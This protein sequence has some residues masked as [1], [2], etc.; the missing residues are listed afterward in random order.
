MKATRITTVRR[1]IAGISSIFLA[2]IFIGISWFVIH[3]VTNE[4]TQSS[5]IYMEALSL[6]FA[7]EA[8]AILEV[9]LDSA[10]TLAQ[11][12]EA[13]SQSLPND[14][15]KLS[16]QQAQVL[17]Q[18][19]S[20]FLRV[21]FYLN[22]GTQEGVAVT[23]NV[24]NGR[25]TNWVPSN[26]LQAQA[27]DGAIS[28]N[29]EQ[30]SE[31]FY[32]TVGGVE[33][34]LISL[35]GPITE[36]GRVIG[37]VG[38]DITTDHLARQL[39]R[40][41]LFDTGFGR[42]MSALGTVVVHPSASRIN[43]PAP[44]WSDSQA[45]ELLNTLEQGNIFTDLYIS[46]ATGEE[47]FK[48][49]VPIQVGNTP[50]PWYFGTVVLPSEVYAST[51]ILGT[52]LS[53]ILLF[54]FL[55]IVT[56]IM[57]VSGK[58]LRPLKNVQEGLSN[59]AQGE[60]DL[61]RTLQV[62]T[63]DE[64][65][66]LS[67]DFNSFVGNLNHIIRDI[68]IALESLKEAGEGVDT[69]M[70]RT[71]RGHSEIESALDGVKKT[72]GNQDL[73]IQTMSSTVEQISGNIE[74]LNSL[75]QRQAGSL[76]ESSSAI[77]EMVAN[78][79]S[80]TNNLETNRKSFE[81][82]DQVSERGFDQLSSVTS[83]ISSI[84]EQSDGLEEANSIITSIASQTNLLAMNAAIE[85]AHA[86]EA[87]KGFAVVADEIRK[88]AENSAEQSLTI[89]ATLK[90]LQ[91][92]IGSVVK[93]AGDSSH[94]FEEVRS[95]VRQVL[96]LQNEMRTAMKEQQTGSEMVLN[97]IEE[98]HRITQE[99]TLGSKEMSTGSEDILREVHQLVGSSQQMS[100]AL[101]SLDRSAETIST[102]ITEMKENTQK[103]AEGIQKVD[104]Q[105]SRFRI[106]V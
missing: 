49:F 90:A 19:N 82:L 20:D 92:A 103:N 21:W 66:A 72:M 95:S 69:N 38:I 61:T 81:K 87:G 26:S 88:L 85:A 23:K 76:S 63:R 74:S 53:F 24:G 5:I 48:A 35:I 39:S 57:T 34:Y 93:D 50:R 10:R 3:Q 71:V 97:S 68:R 64:L 33:L 46:V 2:L 37:A 16:G 54:G 30:I 59:I 62:T 99:V 83:T 105:T 104:E 7:N 36:N 80:V 31:P 22:G 77:E 106:S 1:K 58:I 29:I 14:A 11:G 12:Y 96:A 86:G 40:V 27:L 55:L 101:G 89:G 45:S 94:S 9:P 56:A 78:I 4:K 15:L 67:Q 60:G 84:A 70:S 51:R 13:L 65:G 17:L 41:K 8:D 98:L 6:A 100:I 44:E 73:S 43:K 47:T 18:K 32:E 52:Q 75:I 79:Q 102:A 25:P 91:D 42:L 28:S